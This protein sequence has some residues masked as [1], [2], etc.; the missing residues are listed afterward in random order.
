MGVHLVLRLDA[1]VW[2][3]LLGTT[4]RGGIVYGEE[5]GFY[6][7]WVLNSSIVPRDVALVD[8]DVVGAD[9]PVSN[10]VAVLSEGAFWRRK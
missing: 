10:R 4:G 7:T 6:P 3:E 9:Y 1:F 2:R 5:T 8:E